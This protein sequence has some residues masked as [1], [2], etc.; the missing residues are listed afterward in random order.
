MSV[1]FPARR[2]DKRDA[3]GATIVNSQ[4]LDRPAESG[5]WTLVRHPAWADGRL[6]SSAALLRK[7]ARRF[8]L[9]GDLN[10]G[11]DDRRALHHAIVSQA[12][13]ATVDLRRRARANTD[14]LAL[15][16]RR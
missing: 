11:A 6:A 3:R 5:Q 8:D 10:L 14:H 7:G 1:C 13:V 2:C 12:E 16:D 9:E 15:R 4:K